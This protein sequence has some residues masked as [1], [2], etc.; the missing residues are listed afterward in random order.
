MSLRNKICKEVEDILH[1]KVKLIR[2]RTNKGTSNYDVTVSFTSNYNYGMIDSSIIYMELS[3][4]IEI[5][6][7]PL[8]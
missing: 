7:I 2:Y 3:L 8:C 4:P 1:T 6:E 5:V